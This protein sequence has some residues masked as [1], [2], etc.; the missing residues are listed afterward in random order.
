MLAD[1]K[2]G[3]RGENVFVEILQS[4]LEW[5]IAT[6][7]SA[8]KSFSRGILLLIFY[9]IMVQIDVKTKMFLNEC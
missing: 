4:F 2:K 3:F 9:I 5:E 1:K 6:L 7:N 8:R